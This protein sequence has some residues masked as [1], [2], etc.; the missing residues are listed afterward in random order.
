M[1]L[2]K[3][4]FKQTELDNDLLHHHPKH[5]SQ[6]TTYTVTHRENSLMMMIVGCQ[7]GARSNGSRHSHTSDSIRR[8]GIPIP[9]SYLL[10]IY[11]YIDFLV[12]LDLRSTNFVFFYDDSSVTLIPV[13][14]Y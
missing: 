10:Y 9:F 8:P 6:A 1:P 2:L 12:S 11:I 7:L 4:P 13:D 5:T 14:R 3:V